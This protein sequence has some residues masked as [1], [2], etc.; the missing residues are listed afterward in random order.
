MVA[1]ESP[2]Q[3]TT[4]AN[5]VRIVTQKMPHVHSVSMGVWVNAGARDESPKEGGISHF[6]EH[7]IFKGTERRSAYQI[8]KEFDAIGGVSNAFTAMETTCY[9]AK[10]LDSH[11]TTMVD[12]LV[13]IFLN[14][15]FDAS[16]VERERPVICQE[17]GM[18]EDSPDEYIHHAAARAHWG[19]N[20]LGRPIMGSRENV[21]QFDAEGLKAFFRRLYQPQRIVISAAGNLTHQQLVDLMAPAFETIPSGNDFPQRVPPKGSRGMTLITR[22]IEQQHLC[23]CT[24]GIGI[25]D[26]RRFTF[27]LLNS[28]LGGNM[29][30]R[31]FQKIREQSGLAYAVYSFA[32]S[33]SDTGMF[34]TYAGVHPNNTAEC[35]KLIRKELQ[36]LKDVA[37]TAEELQDAK[38]YTKGNLLLAAE[39]NDNQMVRLAQNEINFGR[40]IPLKN[41]VDRIEA[42]DT[43]SIQALARDLF[44]DSPLTLTLLGP[45]TE[46]T[47]ATCGLAV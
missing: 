43:G 3:K 26:P 47:A 31:L 4:L 15:V 42:V 32:S 13:D 17:I 19:E 34:G 41:V 6:I 27:S 16:E 7:M 11:L 40:Y 9:H 33:F 29:S 36:T 8:A 38:E 37:V 5:G 39:S 21:L 44:T 12:I 30:S 1:T 46:E 18:V 35:L 14:S 2:M 20:P 24:Q 25:T 22:A 28:L 10:V 45:L 23:L